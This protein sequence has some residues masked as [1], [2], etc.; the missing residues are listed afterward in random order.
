MG[1]PAR[2][3]PPG[4]RAFPLDRKAVRRTQAGTTMLLE[5]LRHRRRGPTRGVLMIS[6]KTTLIAHL[7]YPTFAFKAPLIYNPWFEKND[8]DAVVVPMGV[9]PEEYPEFFPLLFKMS[10]IRGALVTMP[11]KVTTIDLVDELTPT[12]AGRR[13]GQRRAAARGRHAA[14]RPVR[15][16]R[17]RP[18]C[19]AQGLRPEGQAGARRRQRRRRLA[20]RGVAGRRGRGRASACSTR[21]TRPRSALGERLARALSRTLAGHRPVRR[22]RRATTSSSTPPRSA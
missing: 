17:V 1:G 19:A 10:N 4:R 22:T 6:G 16:R 15:R 12:A 11:H 2:R 13:R 20:D 21:T 7:G 5:R 3:S 9:K 18:R 8:I 14:R